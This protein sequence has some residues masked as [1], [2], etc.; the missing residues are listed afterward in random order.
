MNKQSSEQ[1]IA[2]AANC[3]DEKGDSQLFLDA[4][5]RELGWDGVKQAGAVL[6]ERV[7]KYQAR[8]GFIDLAWPERSLLIEMKKRGTDLTAHYAQLRSYWMDTRGWR[9]RWLVM[10]NFEDLI[11]WD[12]QKD[13][14]EPVLVTD[15]THVHRDLWFMKPIVEREETARSNAEAVGAAAADAM[16]TL[17]TYLVTSNDDLDE[18]RAFVFRCVFCMVCEDIR[19]L[20]G[21]IFTKIVHEAEDGDAAYDAITQLWAQMDNPRPARGGRL[22][23][24][25]YFNGGLFTNPQP[26]HIDADTLQVLRDACL[27]DWSQVNP[28]IFG[29]LFTATMSADQR[30][31]RGAHFT[32]EPD[33]MKLV[34]PTIIED[35]RHRLDGAAGLLNPKMKGDALTRI[36]MDLEREIIL[37]PT[38]GSGNFLFI[39][40]REMLRLHEEAC[41]MFWEIGVPWHGALNPEN[42]HGID[43]DPFA[44]ELTKL[45]L[46]LAHEIYVTEALN[47]NPWRKDFGLEILPLKNL[48]KTV[49]CADSL[50]ESW[51]AAY[52]IVGNPPFMGWTRMANAYGKEYAERLKKMHK[53]TGNPDFC[54]LFFRKAQ[55]SGAK[56]V[57]LVG[58]S[59]I[60]NQ[61]DSRKYGLQFILDQGGHIRY[62]SAQQVWAGDA[63]VHVSLVSW[64]PKPDL[65]QRAE[66][67][68][69]EIDGK[70][71]NTVIQANL[72]EVVDVRG[73]NLSKGTRAFAQGLKPGHKGFRV[74]SRT[75]AQLAAG[76]SPV[77]EPKDVPEKGRSY[78][79]NQVLMPHM[80]GNQFMTHTENRWDGEYIVNLR[81]WLGSGRAHTDID[82]EIMSLSRHE[83]FRV[84]MQYLQESVG[85]DFHAGKL[86]AVKHPLLTATAGPRFPTDGGRFLARPFMT[87][88]GVVEFLSNISPNNMLFAYDSADDFHYGVFNSSLHWAWACAQGSRL[89]SDVGYTPTTVDTTFPWIELDPEDVYNIRQAAK[90]LQK[91]RVVLRDDYGYSL[92]EQARLT[93]EN[94]LGSALLASKWKLD[95]AVLKAYGLPEDA[96]TNQILLRL[97][98]L[99]AVTD[100]QF[101]P[102][103]DHVRSDYVFFQGVPSTELTQCQSTDPND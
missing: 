48:D 93:Y 39:S 59:A 52:R 85:P 46:M 38:C 12:T 61:I 80:N 82:Q 44:V 102:E 69:L 11:I 99:N 21:Q 76:L 1:F 10:C 9:A 26:T 54:V 79:A 2:Y 45:T 5:F 7:R 65:A 51:G 22:V 64:F 4:L 89:K 55:R 8:M 30:H 49:R 24:V 90:G 60:R 18:A 86:R 13:T 23:G 96:A 83:G 37:D 6:E 57:G 84:V 74:N 33:I 75:A 56:M 68:R 25:P 53:V 40:Y 62:A 50:F 35:Y 70:I 47:K 97:L 15:L 19:I 41:E 36:L 71:V 101:V 81:P 73:A 78:L 94:V 63:A 14:Y 31:L 42:F 100:T 87:N 32:D 3:V 67:G 92:R 27:L 88:S 20:P 98:E 17:F 72:D 43:I 66:V 28:L 95:R 91:A 103:P 29:T 16:A 34:Y 58:S 77:R